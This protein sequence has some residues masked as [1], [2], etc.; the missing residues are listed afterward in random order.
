VEM[1][2]EAL[3]GFLDL[4]THPWVTT[5]CEAILG[6]DY[7]WSRSASTSRSAAR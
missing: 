1:H 6:P 3:R 5:V 4:V 7:R 2:P